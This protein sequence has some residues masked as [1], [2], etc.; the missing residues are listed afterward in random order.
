MY[1]PVV[2]IHVYN[3]HVHVHE[4]YRLLF[5]CTFSPV[6]LCRTI[7]RHHQEKEVMDQR[8]QK[9]ELTKLRKIASNMAKEVKH[10]WDSIQK[11][12]NLL[13]VHVKKLVYN[14][15]YYME[16]IWFHNTCICTCTVLYLPV[17]NVLFVYGSPM[18]QLKCNRY[19]YIIIPVHVLY[20]YKCSPR[21]HNN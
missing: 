16:L 13:H 9:D 5:E 10:F 12:N 21:M 8:A 17:S 20:L 14:L 15:I 18:L 2:S 19:M 7:S 6:Q 3:V 1:S 4:D 11:V